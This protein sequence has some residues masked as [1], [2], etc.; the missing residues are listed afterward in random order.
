MSNIKFCVF[1][2]KP[3]ESKNREH[4]LP[5]WLLR[6]T[7]DPNRVVSMGYHY[8]SG[9]EIS[10]S[11]KSLVTPAC[12]SCNNEYAVLEGQIRPIIESILERKSL[13]VHE[14]CVLLD[15]LDKVRVGL[16]LNY[17]LIMNNPTDIDPSFFINSRIRK[18]DR[19]LA[20]YPM[21]GDKQGLNAYGVE[22]LAFHG[23]PS[24]FGLRINN[25]FIIN[26]SSDY[27]FSAR[28]GFPCPISMRLLLDGETPGFLELGKFKAT[29]KIKFPLF[30]FQLHKPSVLLFQPIM[31]V[32]VGEGGQGSELLGEEL[33]TEQF[34]LEN[35]L[36][37][38]GSGVGKIFRQFSGHV[39]RIDGEHLLVEFDDIA[40]SERRSAG[41]L[42]AQVYVLQTY[43]H[44]L[45]EP[46]TSDLETRRRWSQRLKVMK[47][48]NKAKS[49]AFLRAGS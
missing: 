16:W 5:Q 26:C 14:Y 12:E 39:S 25:V 24:A 15:W 18:K 33:L 34:F 19:L 35:T 40:G 27:L 38:A 17:H 10:F 48:L 32:A 28:C 20:V 47:K 43:L 11:W 46:V 29:K 6:M 23:A 7:G 44:S 9:K 30:K 37:G 1:C 4:V 41:A 22:T 2:G 45:Y 13:P 3:P 31:Q 21:L 8:K 49:S 42:I 36:H